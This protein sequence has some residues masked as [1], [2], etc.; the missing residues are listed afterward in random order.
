MLEY[1]I[2]NIPESVT[3]KE[4]FGLDTRY[5]LYFKIKVSGILKLKY[6][7]TDLEL[8]EFHLK[9]NDGEFSVPFFEISINSER[10]ENVTVDTVY[11]EVTLPFDI[12]ELIV[13]LMI[14]NH[15]AYDLF[16]SYGYTEE[17]KK[18]GEY[19]SVLNHFVYNTNEYKGHFVET[20]LNE[21]WKFLD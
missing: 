10:P 2:K 3:L 20:Y 11:G 17:T 15:Y 12:F 6:H 18:A 13:N 5:R 9:S 1:N 8:K 21:I 19:Y 4:D 16:V 7:E 14:L